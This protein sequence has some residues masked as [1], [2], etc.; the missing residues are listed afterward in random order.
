[1]SAVNTPG[2]I[3]ARVAALLALWYVQ[4]LQSGTMVDQAL[5]AA[6]RQA[7]PRRWP[8]QPKTM[9]DYVDAYRV[10]LAA[11]ARQQGATLLD[12]VQRQ[13][14]RRRWPWQP[15]TIRDLIDERSAELTELAAE[16]SAELAAAVA[17]RKDALVTTAQQ[18]VRPRR[19]PWQP[20]TLRDRVSERS[21]QL[22]TVAAERS[23][24]LAA[25]ARAR[26][27]ALLKQARRQ[28]SSRRWPWQPKTA[29]DR[30]KE[31]S[32]RGKRAL[33][34]Q[35]NSAAER[36]MELAEQSSQTVR[37]TASATSDQVQQL[38]SA[39][40]RTIESAT[41]AAAGSLHDAAQR[42]STTVSTTADTAAA[43]AQ[44]PV[45]AVS[46]SVHA[47]RRTVR[48]GV[49]LFRT[50]LWATLIGVVIGLLFATTS[51][52]ELRRQL[53]RISDQLIRGVRQPDQRLSL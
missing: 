50:A 25:L 39:V 24:E 43:A 37:Q 6:R 31:Q 42:V 10:E 20:K 41:S 5:A 3:V 27:D 28:R 16:W 19:W 1:M 52:E 40:P 7:R 30:L 8:W 23:E 46:D 51:G 29:R 21:V 35:V 17:A 36:L 49:R 12:A 9:R 44:R 26:R 14:Q 34:G 22:A 38:A 13:S 4:V 32:E 47:G 45:S 11:L 33:V 48:R 53:R 18:Q 2:R 15:K